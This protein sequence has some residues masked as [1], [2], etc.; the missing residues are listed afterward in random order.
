MAA[1][2]KRSFSIVKLFHDFFGWSQYLLLVKLYDLSYSFSEVQFLNSYYYFLSY[3]SL[4]RNSARQS[5]F[6]RT[7]DKYTLSTISLFFWFFQFAELQ[8]NY[9]LSIV[10]TNNIF[11]IQKIMSFEHILKVLRLFFIKIDWLLI[12]I[13]TFILLSTCFIFI[14][15]WKFSQFSS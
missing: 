14:S 12:W 7:L 10:S 15:R 13:Y 8:K 3:S 1:S 4:K 6:L 5:C 11:W 9:P 2:L